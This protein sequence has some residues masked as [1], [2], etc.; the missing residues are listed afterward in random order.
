MGIQSFVSQTVART[1][2]EGRTNSGSTSL[3]TGVTNSHY[4]DGR[5]SMSISS[6][7]LLYRSAIPVEQIRG[8]TVSWQDEQTVPILQVERKIVRSGAGVDDNYQWITT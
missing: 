5:K 4:R 3:L 6:Y 7:R 8:I 1:A 2:G